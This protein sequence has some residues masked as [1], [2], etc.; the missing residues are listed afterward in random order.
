MKA[1]KQG[2]ALQL[3][4][5]CYIQVPRGSDNETYGKSD[6][7]IWFSV[8]PDISDS[9]G[10]SYVSEP[11]MGRSMPF[12]SYSH[13]DDRIIQMNLHFII[14]ETGDA[15]LNLAN[16]RLLESLTYPMNSPSGSAAPYLPPAVCQIKC[17]ELLG[18]QPLCVVLKSYSVKFPT[19]VAWD[20]SAAARYIPVKFDVDTTWEVVYS[21]S[22]LPGAERI[23]NSGF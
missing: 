3:I 19:D 21:S 7:T 11:V 8:L 4:P 14:T 12:K 23:F 6:N 9:K 13:S 17:G 10:A 18:S 20:E 2:G 22:N 1:T 5:D 16:L 15:D